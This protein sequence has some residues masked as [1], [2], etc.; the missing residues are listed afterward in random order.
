MP[1]DRQALEMIISARTVYRAQSIAL[2]NSDG[3]VQE[4]TIIMATSPTNRNKLHS[5]EKL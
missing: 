3:S 2:L 5:T 1:T 4:I